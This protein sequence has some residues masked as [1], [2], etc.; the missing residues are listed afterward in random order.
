MQRL[1]S[2]CH[3]TFSA[4]RISYGWIPSD[5]PRGRLGPWGLAACT[6]PLARPARG[7]D[8]RLHLSRAHRSRA[9]AQGGAAHAP[10]AC[11]DPRVAPAARLANARLPRDD[12]AW[13][14]HGDAVSGRSHARI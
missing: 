6:S 11:P 13:R 5:D 14:G 8:L 4:K 9:Q 7:Q 3:L 1:E 2:T 12:A 10:D